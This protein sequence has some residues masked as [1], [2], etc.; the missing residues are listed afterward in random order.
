[1]GPFE[2]SYEDGSIIRS[3]LSLMRLPVKVTFF[4]S[5]GQILYA[6]ASPEMVAGITQLNVRIP[7]N[8]RAGSRIPITITAGDTAVQDVGYVS[9]K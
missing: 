2:G 5:E 7:A 3:N 9:I 4:G 1:M 6:G 8:A